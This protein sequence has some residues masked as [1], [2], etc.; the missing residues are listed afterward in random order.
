MANMAKVDKEFL[1][2]NIA[3]LKEM[4]ISELS[5]VAKKLHVNGTSGLRKQELIFRILA[6]HT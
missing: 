1:T 2:M 6:A 3:E 5:D 4:T